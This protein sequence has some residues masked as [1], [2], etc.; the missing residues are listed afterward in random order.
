M[1]HYAPKMRVQSHLV[2]PVFSGSLQLKEGIQRSTSGV[3]LVKEPAP[4]AEKAQ[5]SIQEIE[6]LAYA[7]W[8][9]RGEPLDGSSEN[10]WIEAERLLRMRTT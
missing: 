1:A 7:L 2:Q 9:E 8:Q 6:T 3:S 10:D 4:R 5:P